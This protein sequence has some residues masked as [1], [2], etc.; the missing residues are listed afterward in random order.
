MRKLTFLLISLFVTSFV[1]GQN[2]QY[3]YSNSGQ[4][5]IHK[6]QLIFPES[7]VTKDVIWADDFNDENI[8][9]WTTYD[10]DGDGNNWFVYNYGD[11]ICLTSESWAGS[12]LTPENWI[13]SPAIDLSAV[14]D[15]TFLEFYTWA[16]DQGWTSEHY[17]VL[18]STT[19]NQVAS[20]TDNIY[21]ETL[22]GTGVFNRAVSLSDYL[23]ETIYI[24]FVHYDCTDMYRLNIDDVSVYTNTEVDLGIT[25]AT[26]PSNTTGC[27]LTNAEAVTITLFNYGGVE[28]SNF[29][30]SYSINGGTPVVET[31]T[32]AIASGA[33]LEYTFT[34]TADLSALGYHEMNFE[35]AVDADVNLTNNVFDK[36]IRSTDGTIVVHALSDSNGDQMWTITNSNGDTVGMFVDYQWDV[37][38][39][40]QVCVLD[41]DCYTFTFTGFDNTG[42]VEI[43]YN[44]VV[45]AGGQTAGNTEGGV[46]WFGIGGGCASVDAKLHAITTPNYA[47]PGD[48]DIS[49]TI[50][51]MGA[52]EITNFDVT[53][54]IDG[55]TESAVYTATGL[56]IGS[57]ET[58]DFVHDIPYN[59]AT[60]DT[61]IINVTVSNVNADE[62]ANTENNTLSK[63]IAITSEQVTRKVLLENFTTGVCP[64]CP[65][66]HTLLENYVEN[67]PNA[68]LVA[69]H[70]GYYTDEMT[71]PENTELMA[72]YNDGGSTYA[73]ALGIDRYHYDEGLTGGAADP[74]PLFFP[75]ADQSATTTRI[76]ERLNVPSFVNVDIY[77]ELTEGGDLELDVVGNIVASVTENDLRLVVYIIEDSLIYNQSGGTTDYQHNNVMRDA[78]S[79]T[80]GDADA[81][82]SNTAGTEFQKHYTYT[83]NA[84]W[85]VDK[86]SIVA[87]VANYDADVNNRAVLNAEK[88]FVNDLEPLVGINSIQRNVRVYPNPASDYITVANAENSLVELYTVT[89]Q[90]VK[91]VKGNQSGAVVEVADLPQ[92]NYIL[93]VTGANVAK[94]AKITIER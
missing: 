28:V 3:K 66:I 54:N 1:V 64:N 93:K 58:Y 73:P 89:G 36:E 8:S 56:N 19:D 38:V 51:N 17:K 69:Q 37:E 30:V 42:W 81:I 35:V 90:L 29:E 46:E 41:S 4:N 22:P 68:I 52:D 16:Q 21:E 10:Q 49:G 50:L 84:S 48:V 34:Q 11:A 74:G 82:S 67:E 26:S 43:L 76:D 55:G 23:G 32:D 62:D 12:P 86:L 24:A 79:A 60:E 80:W 7:S 61:Y 14:T 53:Y 31:V 2:A 78:I 47:L 85:N 71:I 63:S 72:L 70:A 57:G 33:T 88:V 9:D 6:Q 59:F 65:P 77:G 25:G 75:G 94:T 91:S 39:E 18:V 83:P 40:T 27:L 45:V 44:G 13:V 15:A 87:F 92:G 20:F 5:I